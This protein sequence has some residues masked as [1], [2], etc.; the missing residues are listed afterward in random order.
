MRRAA[1]F[2]LLLLLPLA[3]CDRDPLGP[4]LSQAAAPQ[5]SRQ[6][7]VWTN[8]RTGEVVTDSVTVCIRVITP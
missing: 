6:P 1:A 3:G 4:N 8:A 5:C 7:I 2:V